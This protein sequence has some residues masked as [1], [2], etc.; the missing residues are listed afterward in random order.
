MSLRICERVLQSRRKLLR[1]SAWAFGRELTFRSQINDFTSELN[2]TNTKL[3]ALQQKLDELEQKKKGCQSRI[4]AAKS[5]CDQY[6]RSD[7][8]RFK[9]EPARLRFQNGRLTGRGIRLA[10]SSPSLE[11]HS[12]DPGQDRDGT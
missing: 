1:I 11:N 6:T 9:G 3:A 12:D 8:L 7:I 4:A 2:E 10:P 5:K